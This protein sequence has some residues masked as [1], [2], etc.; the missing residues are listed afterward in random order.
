MRHQKLLDDSSLFIINSE[1]EMTCWVKPIKMFCLRSLDA[2]FSTQNKFCCI[3]FKK[4]LL[5]LTQTTEDQML[6]KFTVKCACSNAILV[7]QFLVS[8]PKTSAISEM[9]VEIK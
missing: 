3:A 9:K 6:L 7:T 4:Q 8:G 5:A 2:F 1:H